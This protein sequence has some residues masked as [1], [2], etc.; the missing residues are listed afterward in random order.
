[1]YGCTVYT[2]VNQHSNG[3]WT[4]IEDVFP[5]E[6]GDIPASYVSLPEGIFYTFRCSPNPSNR[7]SSHH[8]QDG[9]ITWDFS[10]RK[11][12]H[13]ALLETWFWG[14]RPSYFPRK[15]H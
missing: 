2:L 11:S 3:K 14:F 9:H 6:N 1:M 5:I 8:Y 4:Q 12:Q 13:K 10:A 7:C 15:I